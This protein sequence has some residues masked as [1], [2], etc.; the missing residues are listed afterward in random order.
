MLAFRLSIALPPPSP[1]TPPMLPTDFL[2]LRTRVTP[3]WGIFS[4]L[5]AVTMALCLS[6]AAAALHRNAMSFDNNNTAEDKEDVKDDKGRVVAAATHAA[7]AA[8]HAA[9]LQRPVS[10]VSPS[11]LLKDRVLR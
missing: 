9:G 1:E 5:I 10:P 11:V 6:H 4:F 7:N 3:L 2:A 8:G